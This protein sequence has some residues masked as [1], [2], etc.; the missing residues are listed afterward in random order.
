MDA[1]SS[2]EILAQMRSYGNEGASASRGDHYY[3]GKTAEPEIHPIPGEVKQQEKDTVPSGDNMDLMRS[4]EN[5]G[6]SVSRGDQFT[7]ARTPEP[8]VH[9][10]PD[11]VK[12]QAMD[13]VS[14]DETAKQIR[15]V[16]DCGDVMP[17][18]SP[19]WGTD[20]VAGKIARTHEQ[21]HDVDEIQKTITQDGFGREL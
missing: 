21:S 10:I 18:P 11:H 13:S 12:Q 4:Y 3:Y 20:Q 5:Q 14:H 1:I 17:G 15:L 8:E 16:K 7:Y 6:M 2:S 19:S 9:P